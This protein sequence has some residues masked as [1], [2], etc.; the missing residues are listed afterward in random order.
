[1]D[2]QKIKR[3]LMALKRRFLSRQRE[4]KIVSVVGKRDIHLSQGRY[5]TE[6]DI[7]KMREA[8]FS[9]TD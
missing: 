3:P 9:R 8:A 4:R 6:Q 1:M 2:N 5:L 7:D